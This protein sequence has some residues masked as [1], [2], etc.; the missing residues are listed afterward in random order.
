MDTP[1]SRDLSSPRSQCRPPR[2]NIKSLKRK[3]NRHRASGNFG[4][5]MQAAPAIEQEMI[6]DF[7]RSYIG[8]HAIIDKDTLHCLALM[9][10]H[11]AP[12]R[13]LD[14]TYSPYVAAYFATES[15]APTGS[16][17]C[18]NSTWCQDAASSII[19]PTETRER[20]QKRDNCSF[21]RLYMSNPTTGSFVFTEN[22]FHL[23]SRS[24][25]SKAYS[26]VQETSACRSLTT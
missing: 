10:H 8:D 21:E 25:F 24:P 11:G 17:W 12:T 3:K 23:L 22:P 15:G 2:F 16:V 7:R 14:W 5:D 6:R 4:L 1:T 26:F 9:Q 18:L 13:L 20:N 19:G